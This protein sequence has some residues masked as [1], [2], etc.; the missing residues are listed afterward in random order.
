MIPWYTEMRKCEVLCMKRWIAG[1]LTLA[2]LAVAA[3]CLVAA[4]P[5][6]VDA[7]EQGYEN[8]LFSNGY[9]GFCVDE[10]LSGANPGDHFTVAPAGELRS[11]GDNPVDI[12]NTIKVMLAEGFHTF[13]AKGEDGQYLMTADG[14]WLAQ[15]VTWH[16]T[17]G[18]TRDDER[19]QE[20]DQMVQQVE[21]WVA[22]GKQVADEGHLFSVDDDTDVTIDF[23]LLN[24]QIEGQQ[25]FFAY[26]ITQSEATEPDESEASGSLPEESDPAPSLPEESQPVSS[27]PEESQPAPSLPEESKPSQVDSPVTIPETQTDI[28]DDIPPKTGDNSLF[29]VALVMGCIS[30]LGLAV[31]LPKKSR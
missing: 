28:T 31:L 26:Q 29:A 30:L 12:S 18:Y 24:T 27:L 17:D 4:A 19:Q 21:T 3:S 5:V 6:T 13:F 23:A 7:R 14:Q 22:Q 20:I 25:C 8:V 11:N 16:Y 2:L 15:R 1:I 9:R 10:G